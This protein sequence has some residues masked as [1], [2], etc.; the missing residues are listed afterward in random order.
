MNWCCHLCGAENIGV[1]QSCVRCFI[2][3]DEQKKAAQ[4]IIKISSSDNEDE[5][6]GELG[7]GTD[8][9]NATN[10]IVCGSSD[11]EEKEEEKA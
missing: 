5:E 11:E 7:E 10:A 3:V 9:T 4:E 2:P 6:F 8:A 1:S